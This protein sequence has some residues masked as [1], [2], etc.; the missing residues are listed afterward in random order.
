MS[1]F[2]L[3][4]M[5][6]SAKSRI[7]YAVEANAN[8]ESLKMKRSFARHEISLAIEE[9]IAA[10]NEYLSSDF[11][12]AIHPKYGMMRMNKAFE[13]YDTLCKQMLKELHGH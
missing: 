3:D 9:M 11:L 7:A 6:Q 13:R 8:Y 1:E 5:V 10:T 12:K 4:D 2:N